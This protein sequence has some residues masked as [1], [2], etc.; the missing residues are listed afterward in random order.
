[1]SLSD[2]IGVIYEGKLIEFLP[3]EEA[4]EEKLGILMTGA[5]QGKAVKE[6]CEHE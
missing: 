3:S 1:M 2:I 5:H 4:S 6:V